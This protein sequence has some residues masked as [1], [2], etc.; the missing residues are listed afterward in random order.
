MDI[1]KNVGVS[2]SILLCRLTQNNCE[3]L[4]NKTESRSKM[5]K[6]H[7]RNNAPSIKKIYFYKVNSVSG[8]REMCSP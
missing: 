3:I 2:K 7:S 8:K 4:C 1:W 6:L 5:L